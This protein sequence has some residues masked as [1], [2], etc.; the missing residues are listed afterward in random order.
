MTSPLIQQVREALTKRFGVN[1]WRAEDE[2]FSEEV[3]GEILAAITPALEQ[4][5]REHTERILAAL[6][7]D[8]DRAYPGDGDIGLVEVRAWLNTRHIHLP[9]LRE[10][11][12]ASPKPNDGGLALAWHEQQLWIEAK[13]DAAMWKKSAEAKQ[14]LLN[15]SESALKEQTNY[16]LTSARDLMGQRD[17]VIAALKAYVEWFG[18]AHVNG[19]PADDTCFCSGSALNDAVNRVL[20][21]QGTEEQSGGGR[22]L[23]WT[24]DNIYTIARREAGKDDPRG[25]WGHIRRLCEVAGCQPRGVLRTVAEQAQGAQTTGVTR[26]LEAALDATPAEG[27]KTPEP[28]KEPTK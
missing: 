21:E 24:L 6:Y 18:A 8:F 15:E 2:G 4:A 3:I 11:P 22:S 12:K 20:S 10:L 16:Y 1:E 5:Q 25:R 7:D 26:Q 27:P 14:R 19:C 23:Q 17:D 28:L 9:I 13:K